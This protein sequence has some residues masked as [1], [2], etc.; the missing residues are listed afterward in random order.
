MKIHFGVVRVLGMNPD[1]NSFK[2]QNIKS[3][4]LIYTL[5]RRSDRYF[6][7]IRP[8]QELQVMYGNDE[9]MEV[10]YP[11]LDRVAD[12]LRGTQ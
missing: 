1:M 7:S 8:G 9:V 3:P 4:S 12:V 6:E 10:M 5:P 11:D 2:V